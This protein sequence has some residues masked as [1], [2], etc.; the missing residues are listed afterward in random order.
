MAISDEKLQKFES[1]VM[2]Q[3]NEQVES[4]LANLNT[5]KEQTLSATE[6][7]ELTR[8]FTNMQN[9]LSQIKQSCIKRVS[10]HAQQANKEMLLHREDIREKVFGS[11]RER[12]ID[13]TKTPEY[14]KFLSDGLKRLEG[15]SADDLVV[16]I[17]ENDMKYKDT[18]FASMTVA[19]DKKIK[20]GGFIL[21]SGEKGFALDETL[22]A[23]LDSQREYFNS[24]SG[25]K[26]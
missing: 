17:G 6:D 16:C 3:A 21:K 2:A 12:L 10:L 13:F 1:A 19:L 24:V 18:I 9:K 26:V 11:V 22:D 14:E 15:Y 20:I 7:A 5:K 23:R 25:L 4:I 8:H